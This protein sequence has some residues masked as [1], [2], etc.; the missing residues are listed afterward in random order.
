ML[1]SS[2]GSGGGS[3]SLSRQP[4]GPAV[5]DQVPGAGPAPATTSCDRVAAPDG[6]DAGP[7][8]AGAPF[9]G[10]QRLIDS[11]RSGQTGCFR[12]GTFAGAGAGEIEVRHPGITLS[13][14]PGERATLKGQ[15][16][17]EEGADGVTVSD[18]DVDSRSRYNLG[19]MI[20]AAD[21]TFDN[22]DVTDF[23]TGICFI[24]GASDPSF[25]RATN[26][27]IENSRI[28][29]C[30]RLPP[31]NNDHGIYVAHS[32]GAIIRNNWIYDNA[33]RGIQ[34]FPDAQ[35]T[36]VY[37]NVID[38]NGEGVI[39]SGDQDTASSDNLVYGNV[40]SN[41][42]QR[43][44]VESYWV[45]PVGTGN[46]VRDNCVW[47]SNADSYYNRDGGVVTH[48]NGA[49]R[50]FELSGDVRAEPGFRDAESDD[51]RLHGGPCAEQ[52][53]APGQ[54]SP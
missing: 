30:G 51:F 28:H 6:N 50:G 48:P 39:F 43:W 38:G 35:G 25:G 1:A 34:L 53:A 3:S 47:A 24:L 11:L 32:D 4:A 41:S 23:H 27:V 26:A 14:F 40:I 29:D 9:R 13:S 54:A 33:D 15:L 21:T 18:L 31:E 10:V 22:V 16:K 44:N 42:M 49:P 17:I 20:F 5:F 12:N 2:C 46:V 45:G 36:R 52:L 8:T 37:G 19:P 7:G